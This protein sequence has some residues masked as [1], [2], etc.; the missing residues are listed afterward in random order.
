MSWYEQALSLLSPG[1]VGSIIGIAGLIGAVIV[2]LLTRQRTSV[3]YACAGDRVLGPS[4]DDGLPPEIT[5]QYKGENIPRLT[6]STVVFWNSGEKTILGDDIVASDPLRFCVADDGVILSVTL[7]KT[8]R[9]V[10]E[11]SAEFSSKSSKDAYFKFG[12]LDAGDGAV[13]EILHTSAKRVL[14]VEGTLRGLPRGMK[15]LGRITG[16][17]YGK[18]KRFAMVIDLTATWAPMILGGGVS[19]AAIFV[20]S[21]SLNE[22]V[23][24]TPSNVSATL[25]GAG[26]TYFLL[27][28]AM[29]YLFRR[30]YPKHLHVEELE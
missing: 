8:S 3:D 2:Y 10:N 27:G 12:F 28:L 24:S 26:V 23:A 1:W 19:L 20:P 11:F 30:K 25:L 14:T 21:E 17:I 22:F 29:L 9:T 13:V 4:T 5:V 7:L 16:K 18:R 15:N 6:R